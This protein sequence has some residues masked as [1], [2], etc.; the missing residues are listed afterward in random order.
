MEEKFQQ[1]LEFRQRAAEAHRIAQEAR[2]P[3]EKVDIFAVERR[4]LSL[5]RGADEKSAPS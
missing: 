5:A 2:D 4:W 1:R 3:A